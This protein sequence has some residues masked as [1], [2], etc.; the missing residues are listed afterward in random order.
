[1]SQHS[2]IKWSK[3]IIAED[4]NGGFIICDNC[5]KLLELHGERLPENIHYDEVEVAVVNGKPLVRLEDGSI[6]EITNK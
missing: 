5:E 3:G 1:M 4:V 2:K 6:L